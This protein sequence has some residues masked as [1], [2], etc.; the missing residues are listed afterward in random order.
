[1][2]RVRSDG[3]GKANMPDVTLSY[4]NWFLNIAIST[5]DQNRPARNPGKREIVNSYSGTQTGK[6]PNTRP[7]RPDS[8]NHSPSLCTGRILLATFPKLVFGNWVAK[9]NNPAKTSITRPAHE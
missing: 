9:A 4:D 8:F 1:M 2:S 3:I 6:Y 5:T 7:L